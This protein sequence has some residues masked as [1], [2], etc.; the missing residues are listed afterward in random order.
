MAEFWLQLLP[1]TPEGRQLIE[2]D[3]RKR[4]FQDS[5][6]FNRYML[7]VN[8]NDA[9]AHRSLAKSLFLGGGPLQ[10]TVQHL[11]EALRLDPNDDETHYLS[12]LLL[13]S[14]KH[15]P[16]AE[17]TRAMVASA[18][19]VVVL[20]DGSKLGAAALANVCSIDLVD[21]LVTDRSASLEQCAELRARG[22]E[23]VVAE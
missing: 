10:E 2:N 23:V 3:Y 9:T 6:E 19:R 14:Q 15:L 16:E 5:L 7:S 11:Q 4:V 8:P 18:R 20:A 17:M 13:R 21:V 12:G 22:V 1:R